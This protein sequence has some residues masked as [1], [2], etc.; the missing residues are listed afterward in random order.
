MYT[1]AGPNLARKSKIKITWPLQYMGYNAIFQRKSKTKDHAVKNSVKSAQGTMLFYEEVV[2]LKI[3]QSKVALTIH[4]VQCYF[5]GKS[6]AK[7]EPV[8]ISGNGTI[9][10]SQERVRLKITQSEMK[11]ILNCYLPKEE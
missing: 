7:K 8:K 1:V 9:V 2:R 10:F 5:P 6:K 11:H 3:T 4:R